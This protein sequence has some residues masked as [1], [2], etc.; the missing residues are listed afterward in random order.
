MNLQET[1]I[2]QLEAD[3]KRLKPMFRQAAHTVVEERVSNYPIFVAHQDEAVIGIPL[4]DSE[5]HG[6]QWSYSVSSLEELVAKKIILFEKVN[7]FRELYK[8]RPAHVC[9]F[10]VHDTAGGLIFTPY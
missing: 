9:V 3:L 5:Q 8:Q 4:V 10:I 2:E 1:I 6:T 7:E